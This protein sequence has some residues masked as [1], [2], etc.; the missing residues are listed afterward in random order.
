[1]GFHVKYTDGSGEHEVELEI[2]PAEVEYPPAEAVTVRTS[3]DGNVIL[4][5]PLRDSR[6][7]KWIWNG[8]GPNHSAFAAQWALLQS[9]GT[10]K[11]LEGGLSPT[12]GIWEDVSGAGGF[13]RMDG[14][15]KVYT[16]VRFVQ[17]TRKPEGSGPVRYTAEV[18][19]Y[20]ADDSY[21]TY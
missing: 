15:S 11:R 17:V 4:Q 21:S 18:E 12:I 9:L 13:D 20:L 2:A 1:M 8:Y 14:P 16:T 19:F 10:R 6:P 3:Q 7:R 5:R